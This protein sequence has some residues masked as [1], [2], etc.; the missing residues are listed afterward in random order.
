MIMLYPPSIRMPT[1]P[2]PHFDFS[3]K[4]R[5]LGISFD[6]NLD[7]SCHVI[8]L[9]RV[10]NCELRR[11]RHIRRY[12]STDACKT[13]VCSTIL[14]RIDYCNSILYNCPTYL[15]DKLQRIQNNAARL[16]VRIPKYDHISCHLSDLHWL[17]IRQ[18]ICFKICVTVYKILQG[19][20]P[21]YLSD[22]VSVYVPR[23]SL[24]SSDDDRI[25]ESRNYRTRFGR[26]SFSYAAPVLWNSLPRDVRNS[27][28]LHS[29]KKSLKTH[30]ISS[31]R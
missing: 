29:F 15:L 25:L 18:R 1:E 9:I 4:V 28:S 17:R 16:I 23:R 30:F 6:R 22:L 12:L 14:S 8:N 26:R 2:L 20:C 7:S 3:Q 11:L 27:A 5:N 24:R 13:V 21:S 10:L 19:S 31:N